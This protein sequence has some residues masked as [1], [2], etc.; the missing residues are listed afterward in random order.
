[1]DELATSIL[2]QAEK[3]LARDGHVDSVAFVV[4][5][6]AVAPVDVAP[7]FATP[8]GKALFA[9]VMR[10]EALFGAEMLG[11]VSEAWYLHV[12]AGVGRPPARSIAYAAGRRECIQ[13]IV[14][15]K[16]GWAMNHRFFGRDA[17]KQP[18]LEELT[19]R[20]STDSSETWDGQM[21]NWYRTD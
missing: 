5:D 3:L 13:V 11:L 4:R 6:G 18:V 12:E 10:T 21:M 8:E 2:E 1:M 15:S 9:R 20:R 17:K 7:L 14:Q 16:T 19:A